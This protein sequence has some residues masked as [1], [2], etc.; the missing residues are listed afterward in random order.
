MSRKPYIRPIPKCSWF[1][2]N[3]RYKSYMMREVT[4]LFIGGYTGV[5]TMGLWR[6]MQGQAA[7]DA[8]LAALHAPSAIIFHVLALVFAVY[9]SATWFNV[10]PQ[11]MPI[12]QGDDFL[13]G[14]VIITAHYAGWAIASLVILLAVGV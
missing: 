14:S 8:F 9:H 10:T 5:L 7:Y 1:M 6:L 3:G 13:P 2:R 12:M 4:C 11:A